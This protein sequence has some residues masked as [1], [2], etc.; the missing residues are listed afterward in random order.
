MRKEIC[1]SSRRHISVASVCGQ[2]PTV[3][4]PGRHGS[5]A[6]T[7]W[8]ATGERKKRSRFQAV[9]IW[10]HNAI[11]T[12]CLWLNYTRPW[13]ITHPFLDASQQQRGQWRQHQPCRRGNPTGHDC[14]PLCLQFS[15]YQ[16]GSGGSASKWLFLVVTFPVVGF[17]FPVIF[18]GLCDLF[19][20][21]K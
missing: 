4:L 2:L 21:L 14:H 1:S 19:D 7:G 10:W 11:I 15:Y 5:Q 3:T 9:V 6:P 18:G 13:G 16:G 20:I 12:V 17:F 8:R